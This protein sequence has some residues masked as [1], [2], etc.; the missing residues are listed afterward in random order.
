MTK[1]LDT[2]LPAPLRR[3]L[4]GERLESKVGET[5]VLVTINEEG[6]PHL[7]LLSVGELF[8][9]ASDE[10]RIALWPGTRTTA[11]LRRGGRA[12]LAA[13]LDGTAYYIELEVEPLAVAARPG[14]SLAR[15]RARVRRSRA[16]RVEYADLVSGVRFS[17]RDPDQVLAHWRHVVD[18]LRA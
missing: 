18:S 14:D 2:S 13:F 3:L 9:P 5:F 11:N 1:E 7:A 8:S 10:V 16:D 12:T 4:D 17:L 15:F 6:W